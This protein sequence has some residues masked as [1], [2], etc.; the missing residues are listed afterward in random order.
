M[1]TLRQQT[2]T[3]TLER[4]EG[5]PKTFPHYRGSASPSV[6]TLGI[7]CLSDTQPILRST[8]NRKS[9]LKQES[10][11][12]SLAASQALSLASAPKPCLLARVQAHSLHAP[13]L[14]RQ[15]RAGAE[16]GAVNLAA[17]WLFWGRLA[18]V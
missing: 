7:L 9:R 11:A 8:S 3:P 1:A 13:W 6:A 2:S 16:N 10:K 18:Q 4:V 12:T 17:S 15:H 5:Q 14:A